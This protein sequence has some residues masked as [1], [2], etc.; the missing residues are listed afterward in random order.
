LPLLWLRFTFICHSSLFFHIFFILCFSPDID[1]CRYALFHDAAALR[2]VYARFSCLF[3]R[4][5]LFSFSAA[6]WRCWPRQQFTPAV[7]CRFSIFSFRC[8]ASFSSLLHCLLFSFYF[9]PIAI[10]FIFDD[11][12][13]LISPLSS[14]PA[15][16]IT[17]IVHTSFISADDLLSFF[18]F[19]FVLRRYIFAAIILIFFDI[20]LRHDIFDIFDADYAFIDYVTG[21]LF[22]YSFD[23]ADYFAMPIFADP[24]RSIDIFHFHF[25]RC[26]LCRLLFC[27][28]FSLFSLLSC[29]SH[30]ALSLLY[31]ITLSIIID[32]S[33]LP[34]MLSLIAIIFR[35]HFSFFLLIFFI[36]ASI[37]DFLLSIIAAD[38]YR[39]HFHCLRVWFF[40]SS[41]MRYVIMPLIMGAG[42]SPLCRFRCYVLF[43]CYAAFDMILRHFHIHFRFSPIF[44]FFE[45]FIPPCRYYFLMILLFSMLFRLCFSLFSSSATY[46][47]FHYFH[48][49]IY[50][51]ITII[52]LI[53][54][55]LF[56]FFRFATPLFSFFIS[57]RV[58]RYFHA[59]FSLRLRL[60]FDTLL[61]LH[62]IFI[63]SPDYFITIDYFSFTLFSL[64][65]IDASS[66]SSFDV[67][68]TLLYMSEEKKE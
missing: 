30:K 46:A 62:F 63:I 60:A 16:F 68:F 37:I 27:W 51:I 67:F 26:W 55:T 56:F 47:I 17:S 13:F 53:C 34:L 36:A 61:F 8:Y 20:V 64:F 23:Y 7:T 38:Y 58:L 66:F 11:I 42:F 54:H 10:F 31:A 43:R 40:S 48:D 24:L 59:T 5:W 50:A 57:M 33:A 49:I 52:S 29:F 12:L 14:S 44:I 32:D 65:D 1:W 2:H 6:W 22:R 28:L 41:L 45:L 15:I 18:A 25:L 4:Y 3:L 9:S 19:D 21:Q 35:R 39:F